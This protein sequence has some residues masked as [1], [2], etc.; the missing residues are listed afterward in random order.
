VDGEF[1]GIEGFTFAEVVAGVYN[2]IPG[3]E[4]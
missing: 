4:G 2:L 1:R 3:F